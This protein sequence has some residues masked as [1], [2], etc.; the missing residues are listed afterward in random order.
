MAITLIENFRAA[1]Y[2]PFYAS[3][4]LGAYAEEGL[5]VNV[6]T[7]LGAAQTIQS[8][9]SGQ[10][11]VSWGGPM[12]L[13]GALESDPA[14]APVVFCEVVGRDPF[15]LLGREPSA[16]FQFRNLLGKK[17]ATV[18]E[19]PTPWMCLQY[20]LHLAGVDPSK[21]SRIPARSMLENVSAL[22]SG[23]VDVIQVFHPFA[24]QLVEQGSAHIWYSAADRG[25]TSYTTLNTTR[26][27][28]ERNPEVLLRISRAMYR[29]Q[30]WIEAHGGRD[31]AEAV[32]AFFPEIPI[33]TLTACYNDYKALGIWNRTPILSREGFERLRNAGL[34]TGRL[35]RNFCYEECVDLRFA[36]Q[37]VREDPPSL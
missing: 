26:D 1:F 5:E 31:L 7:S 23:E 28:I 11:E 19:V 2:A 3:C 24:R 15:F 32:A 13:M 12:R 34:S 18:S 17:V 22:L 6:K 36:G 4:A 29:T 25:P 8:L 10:G 20:D 30:K 37:V 35:R 16:E 27:F 21:I 33:P 9:L 14:R